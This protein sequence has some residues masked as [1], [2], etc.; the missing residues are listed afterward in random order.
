MGSDK[1]QGGLVSTEGE[2]T[3]AFMN[4]ANRALNFTTLEMYDIMRGATGKV[5]EGGNHV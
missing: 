3:F 2:L 5:R 1:P 4:T